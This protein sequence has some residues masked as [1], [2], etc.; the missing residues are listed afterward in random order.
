MNV[1]STWQ[2]S[3]C[4]VRAMSTRLRR[5]T[6]MAIRTASVVAVEPS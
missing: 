5:V 1:S 2:Y 6:R 4:T 3:G